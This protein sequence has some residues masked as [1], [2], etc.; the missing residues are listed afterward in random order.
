MYSR[1]RFLDTFA[2]GLGGIALSSLLARDSWGAP[3]PGEAA[4]PPPHHPPKARRVIQVFLQG[5]LSQVDS[6][7]YKPQL[8]KS[9]GRSL[10]S[11]EKPDV[12]FG[13]VGL[14]RANDWEFKQRGQSGLWISELF[15]HIATVADELCVINSMVAE[16]SSHTPATFQESS[17]FRLNGFP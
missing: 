6:F 11:N 8:V 15:P 1:R 3:V 12:F 7:D 13:K 5:G 16:S 4:D 9:H 14:L 2:T 10:S 17:G